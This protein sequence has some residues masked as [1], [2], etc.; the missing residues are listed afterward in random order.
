MEHYNSKKN[1][2]SEVWGYGHDRSGTCIV[3]DVPQHIGSHGVLDTGTV[4]T[5]VRWCYIAQ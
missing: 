2:E 4:T 3:L 5:L 1:G